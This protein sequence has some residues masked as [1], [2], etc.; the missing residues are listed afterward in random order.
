MSVI[1][2]GLL[3]GHETAGGGEG[4]GVVV[5]VRVE[6]AV[7]VETPHTPH[8]AGQLSLLCFRLQRFFVFFL[9]THPHDLFL[10]LS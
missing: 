10:F 5:G 9:L 7:R 2:N 1:E 8:V 6:T 3:S 4:V